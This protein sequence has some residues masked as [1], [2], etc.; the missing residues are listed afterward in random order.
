MSDSDIHICS[1]NGNLDGLNELIAAG[2]VDI[3]ESGEYG[4]TPLYY[5]SDNGRLE[6]VN[7]LVAAG[8]EVNKTDD[9]GDTP[10]HRASR[11]GH[12]EVVKAL[13]RAKADVRIENNQGK[14]P[15]DVARTN[16]IRQ[17]IHEHHPW[18]RRGPLILTR[19]HDD[20]ATNDDHKL[21]AL[22]NIVTA[23]SS[24]NV[25]LF[26]IKRIIVSFL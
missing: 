6:V 7:V 17:Y 10:L 26:D 15:V 23:T 19:P 20:H 13:I 12:S 8:A 22:G 5:A 18:Q 14:A 16:E 3:N 2:G 4:N 9:D 11:N 1:K 21:T 24:G 25:E